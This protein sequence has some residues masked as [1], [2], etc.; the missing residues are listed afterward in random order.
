MARRNQTLAHHPPPSSL[1]S[2]REEDDT[3]EGVDLHSRYIDDEEM[4]A[5]RERM[6]P[7]AM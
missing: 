1:C 6:A 2:A 5:A 4:R 7:L 3:F